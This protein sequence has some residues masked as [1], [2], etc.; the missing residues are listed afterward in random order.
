MMEQEKDYMAIRYKMREKIW[1]RKLLNLFICDFMFTCLYFMVDVILMLFFYPIK[2]IISSRIL[3]YLVIY[4]PV[5]FLFFL[6]IGIFFMA[7]QIYFSNW[8][9]L[10]FVFLLFIVGYFL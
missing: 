2:L 5:V 10:V 7:L 3:V 4:F 8:R 1:Y 9:A 6:L